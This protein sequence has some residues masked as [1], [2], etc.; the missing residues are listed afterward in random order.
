MQQFADAYLLNLNLMQ[1]GFGYGFNFYGI[2]ADDEKVS[3]GVTLVRTNALASAGING[4]LKLYG[5]ETLGGITN[6]LDK[7]EFDN[8]KFANGDAAQAEFLQDG[9]NTFFKAVIE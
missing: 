4:T 5:G 3:V 6:L 2:S 7:A 9:A 1:D 8:A